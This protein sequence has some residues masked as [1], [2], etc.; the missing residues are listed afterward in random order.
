MKASNVVSILAIAFLYG[1]TSGKIANF[2]NRNHYS[3]STNFRMA[4]GGEEGGVQD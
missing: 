3:V 4:Q 2:T 1:S